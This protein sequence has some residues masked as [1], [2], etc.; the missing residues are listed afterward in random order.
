[1]GSF[2]GLPVRNPIL[3]CILLGRTTDSPI[4]VLLL[5]SAC[6][7]SRSTEGSLVVPVQLSR[8]SARTRTL[9]FPRPVQLR[10]A[11]FG[12]RCVHSPCVLCLYSGV[13]PETMT[14]VSWSRIRFL[15]SLLTARR[16]WHET[17]GHHSQA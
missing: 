5:L 1:M 15:V 6:L 8:L 14:E 3:C 16:S 2:T 13:T 12:D 11:L 17:P 9:R 4:F 10:C 7:E